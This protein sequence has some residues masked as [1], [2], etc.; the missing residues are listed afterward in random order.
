MKRNL[1]RVFPWII[2]ARS[3]NLALTKDFGRAKR[4]L[5]ES[6]EVVGLA[7]S[8]WPIFATRIPRASGGG[9]PVSTLDA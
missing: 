8:V 7:K 1:V 3:L 6:L 5:A 9:T 2:R 4:T